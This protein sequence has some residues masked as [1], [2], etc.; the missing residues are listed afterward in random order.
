[1]RRFF[2]TADALA[3][4]MTPDQLAWEERAGR[5]RRAARGVYVEGPA[6]PNRFDRAIGLVIGT[7][8]VASGSLAGVLHDLDNVGLLGPPHETLPRSRQ[9]RS[10]GTRHRDRPPERITCVNGI[11]RTDGLQTLVDLAVPLDDLRWEQAAESAFHK[12]LTSVSALEAALPELA[13]ARTPAH[14]ESGA[15]SRCVRPAR[16]RRRA[17]WRR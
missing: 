2:T 7:G 6:R 5:W 14:R 17:C 16:P 10:P 12:K 1:M 3:E 8:G 15:C 9:T 13:R 11:R 4:G